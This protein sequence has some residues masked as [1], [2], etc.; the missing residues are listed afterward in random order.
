MLDH[1]LKK[2]TQGHVD[3][4][5]Q[6]RRIFFLFVITAM[7]S[8]ALF[9]TDIYLPALPAMATYFNCTPPEIQASFTVFL[10]GLAICQLVYGFLADKF[11]RKKITL[12]GLAL[13]TFA[14]LLCAYTTTLSEFLICRLLQSVGGGVGSVMS[15]AIIA[16]RFNRTEAVK[17]FSTTFPIIGLSGA[18]A[19]WIGGYLTA[20]FGWRST[21]Y[22]ISAFGF[23]VWLSVLFF[24]K[25]SKKEKG[26]KGRIKQSFGNL[27]GYADVLR[28]L[29]FLGYALV[30]CSAFSVFRC[31]SV[32]SP[33]VFDSQGYAAEEMGSFYIALSIAYVMGNLLA[34]RLVNKMRVEQVLD[35]GFFFFVLGGF[36]MVLSTSYFSETPYAI[37]LPM[38]IITFG[39]GFL[40]PTGS[41][42]AMSSVPSEFSGM[43]SGLMG[44]LQFICGAICINWVGQLC[45]GTAL[46]MSFFISGIIMMG[47]CS[48]KL[49]ALRTKSNAALN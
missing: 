32:E 22:F 26:E 18:I 27:F 31:Y 28:N 41:A 37:I 39:N 40:F 8:V 43:A 47:L 13:F 44:A 15:R 23:V 21:F 10:L 9:A 1:Y 49:L 7:G 25:E 36:S 42:G 19:P 30:I 17:V 24:L 33:F 29:N 20:Y 11:G 46:L 2:S 3:S 38:A 4:M 14:S 35:I 12:I 6:D 48:Y 5:V 16:D 34:K 45:N